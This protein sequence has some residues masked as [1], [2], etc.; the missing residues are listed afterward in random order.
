MSI[1]AR[2]TDPVTS[3]DAARKISKSEVGSL[4]DG[5]VEILRDRG[6][7]T[8]DDLYREYLA[9]ALTGRF[10]RRS[11]QRLRT[12]CAELE[13]DGVIAADGGLGRSSLGNGSRKWR[14][15]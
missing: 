4:K 3:F 12:S 11:A 5:I 1:A 15:L 6:P 13:R 9:V 2:V 7:L 14:V 10:V 8:S